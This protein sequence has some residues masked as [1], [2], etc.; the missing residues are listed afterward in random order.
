MLAKQFHSPAIAEKHYQSLSQADSVSAVPTISQPSI[1]TST[2]S[3]PQI[4]N[5]SSA[6]LTIS[7]PPVS[8]LILPPLNCPSASIVTQ[9]SVLS[10]SAVPSS[11][12]SAIFLSSPTPLQCDS[13][14]TVGHMLSALCPVSITPLSCT[15]RTIPSTSLSTASYSSS[16]EPPPQCSQSSLSITVGHVLSKLS[17]D[18]DLKSDPVQVEKNCQEQLRMLSSD[19][20]CKVLSKLFGVFVTRYT[21]IGCLPS[22]FLELSVHAMIHLKHCHR[23]NV[24]YLMA[25]ALGTMRP[26]QSDS[27]LPAKRM[28]MGLIEYSAKFFTA[29]STRQVYIMSQCIMIFLI[30]VDYLPI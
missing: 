19:Q 5:V 30:F 28:P 12:Q 17:S 22:D 11:C 18:S 14:M 6:K 7:Q 20:Q 26:D 23:S 13:L 24:I 16:C 8:S 4:P 29:S 9:S 10:C 21:D 27:L 2:V 1:S 15:S 3:L 25:K